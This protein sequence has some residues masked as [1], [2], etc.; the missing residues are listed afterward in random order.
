MGSMGVR[1]NPRVIFEAAWA[2][3]DRSKAWMANLHLRKGPAMLRT[4]VFAAVA[5]ISTRKVLFFVW[6]RI[7][8]DLKF[9]NARSTVSEA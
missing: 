4:G 9:T 3:P 6:I 2:A 5:S 8:P 7:Y 1:P